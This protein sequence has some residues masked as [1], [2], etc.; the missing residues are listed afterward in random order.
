MILFDTSVCIHL[1]DG[2]PA[3]LA[4]A[5]Q[6]RSA[7]ISTVTR[8]ELAAGLLHPVHGPVRALRNEALLTEIV[9]LEL[10]ARE[11]DVYSAIIAATGFSRRKL[12]DRLIA[13]TALVHGLPLATMN[14]VDFADVPGLEVLDWG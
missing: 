2:D 12:L 9:T 11:A 4:K 3:V 14:P 7:S 13:A 6:W 10:G 8:V 1:R 5:A